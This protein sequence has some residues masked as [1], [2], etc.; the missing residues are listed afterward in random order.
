MNSVYEKIL[1]Y[2]NE[3]EMIDTHEHLPCTE[4][5]WLQEYQGQAGDV[6]KEYLKHYFPSDLV[7]AGLPQADLQQ[8]MNTDLPL[9]EKWQ[10]LE[11][12][13]NVARHTGY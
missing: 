13:W 7:S 1:E 9:M 11:P 3:L 2:V 8:V 12:Y 10:L 4:E 5:V 6:F